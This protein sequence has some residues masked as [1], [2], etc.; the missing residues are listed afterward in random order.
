V[1]VAFLGP[2]RSEAANHAHEPPKVMTLPLIVL[3]IPSALGG[4]FGVAQIYEKQLHE[5]HSGNSAL[6][7]A[8]SLG[9]IILGLI[10]AVRAYWNAAK[11]PLPEKLG[12]LSTAMRNRFYFDEFYEATLI[13]LHDAAAAV[14]DWVDRWIVEGFCVGLVRGGT[15]L[16]GRALRLAQTG[17]LQ[18][19]AFLIVLGVAVV[20]WFVLGK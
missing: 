3:A 11:D 18:T 15:D 1:L 19:Y 20:L 2:A 12:T 14:A 4:F 16:T 7:M 17:N 13:R 9:A 10:L 8:A 5:W 6:A